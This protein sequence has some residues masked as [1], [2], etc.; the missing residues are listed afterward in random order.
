MDLAHQSADL[1][2]ELYSALRRASAEFT[3]S[4]THTPS[5]Q[6]LVEAQNVQTKL[7]DLRDKSRTYQKVWLSINVFS[8]SIFVIAG[9][10][11]LA[12]V[13]VLRKR[14]YTAC[15]EVRFLANDHH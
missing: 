5:L 7:V 11:S 1:R 13:V 8:V 6:T 14:E 2:L 9:V 12:F 10:A 3:A 4:P 15:I